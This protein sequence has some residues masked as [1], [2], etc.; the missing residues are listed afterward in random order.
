MED[1]TEQDWELVVG[2]DA[3]TD[4]TEEVVLSFS[5]ARIRY[6]R[7]PVNL[8]IYGNWNHLI[9][10]AKGRYVCI[11][12]DHDQYLPTILERSAQILDQYPTVGFVHT[13]AM[14]VTRE[15]EPIQALISPFDQVMPGREF[16]KVHVWRSCVIAA[17]AMVRR[18]VYER[19][20]LY[21]EGR[22]LSADKEFWLR[23][24]ELGGV[25]YVD[26]PQALIQARTATDATARYSG[27][28]LAGKHRCTTDWVP[29]LYGRGPWAGLIAKQRVRGSWGRHLLAVMVKAGMFEDS[30][31]IEDS[32]AVLSQAAPLEVRYAIKA[33]GGSRL[34]RAGLKR[35]VLPGYL[36]ELDRRKVEARRLCETFPEIAP[37][38]VPRHG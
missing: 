10:H 23:A 30:R 16:Q 26:R 1:Q 33:I 14:L 12:H 5:D 35:W 13:A 20:G 11:Y 18:T 32:A 19:A 37:H 28:D 2:D 29:R 27:K 25:G 6:L 4:D 22:G 8:G 21:D 9:R 24:A 3:S 34:L 17:T 7:N 15:G 36:R 31:T 38:V